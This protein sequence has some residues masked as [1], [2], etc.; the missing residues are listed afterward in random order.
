MTRLPRSIF[1]P[2][3]MLSCFAG[4]TVLAAATVSRSGTKEGEPG[5]KRLTKLLDAVK[6]EQQKIHTLT[7]NF[8]EEKVSQLLAKP[9]VSKGRFSYE[10]P[11]KVRWEY[12]KPDPITLVI[13]G[14]EMTT[15]FRDLGT[16]NK[17]K[18]S[19]YS[20]RVLQYMGAGVSV[21]RLLSYFEVALWQPGGKDRDY[22]LDL[23]P[24]YDRLRKHLKTMTV[25][26]DSHTHLMTRLRY[27]EPDGDRTEY[28]L[29]DIV[30]NQPLPAD[31]FVVKLPPGVH[32]RQV[33]LDASPG[34]L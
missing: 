12:E 21:D 17:V 28:R 9:A 3:L 31:R 2:V 19:R 6:A 7:A 25:W 29:S 13:Q 27:E 34:A 24:R 5:S 30:V 22:R 15:W 20:R 11:D 8:T 32:L 10:A 33:E 16:A 4:T 14:D 1:V 23:I 26:I 18:V